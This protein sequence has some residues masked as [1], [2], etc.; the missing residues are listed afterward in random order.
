MGLL[1]CINV[2]ALK[3]SLCSP[4]IGS[5][6]CSKFHQNRLAVVPILIQ[7]MYP[8]V[9]IANG[10]HLVSQLPIQ[11]TIR[12]LL[13]LLPSVMSFDTLM[14]KVTHKIK[15]SIKSKGTWRCNE[16]CMLGDQSPK[17]LAA[18]SESMQPGEMC[19]LVFMISATIST[20]LVNQHISYVQHL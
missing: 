10:E 18:T 19:N 11:C 3:A 5:I 4:N 12:C 17:R 8:A 2:L 13:L 20:V 6:W 7:G 14:Q 16:Q 9:T 15:L 1:T